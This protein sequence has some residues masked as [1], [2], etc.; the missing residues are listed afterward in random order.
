[1]IF[2]FS[3]AVENYA[4]SWEWLKPLGYTDSVFSGSNLKRSSTGNLLITYFSETGAVLKSD[5]AFCNSTGDTLWKK[6]F[7]N[8]A[9][10]DTYI[11]SVDNIYF[12]GSFINTLNINGTI[13]NSYGD[14]DAIIGILDSNGNYLKHV[15]FGTDTS[16]TAYSIDVYHHQVFATG[17]YRKSF[18]LDGLS[19]TG[20][21][22][23]NIFMLKLDSNLVALKKFQTSQD[24]ITGNAFAYKIGVGKND[25][26]YFYGG[27]YG[28]MKFDSTYI[29]SSC[30]VLAKFSNDLELGWAKQIAC[31]GYYL[32]SFC[33]DSHK[34]LIM[35]YY[36]NGGGG[37]SLELEVHKFDP[38]WN[39]IWM[40]TVPVC[41]TGYLDVDDSDNVWIAGVH[42]NEFV[43]P[44]RFSVVKLSPSGMLTQVIYDTT[45]AHGLHGFAVKKNNDFYIIGNCMMGSYLGAYTCS[46]QGSGFLAHYGSD[47]LSNIHSYVSPEKFQVFPNP[48]QGRFTLQLNNEL[49][50]NIQ[51]GAMIY[52]Y[53]Q[54]GNCIL[55]QK[56]SNSSTQ[57]FDISKLA[58][59]NYFIEVETEKERIAKKLILN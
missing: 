6:E 5:L 53:D 58:K 50:K 33:F 59:G 4:Q 25:S 56:L 36:A 20:N 24:S 22:K 26:V 51:Q 13:I 3:R 31:Y 47:G 14:K 28:I 29:Y 52:I 21:G 48:A 43:S 9:I 10:H 44:P 1:M 45:I 38:E 54:L 41:I 32:P 16:E 49:Q 23:Q 30:Q 7:P 40:K 8:L 19:F 11:D 42:S 57:Q 2:L 18:S 55:R 15:A 17:T 34:N 27:S 35:T 37:W 46:P 39:M 12:A